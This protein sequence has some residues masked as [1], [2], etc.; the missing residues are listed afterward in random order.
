MNA[1]RR[2]DGWRDAPV[3]ELIGAL[4]GANLRDS[5]RFHRPLN[6]VTDLEKEEGKP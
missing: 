4:P 5:E 6:K 2:G 1:I 3:M